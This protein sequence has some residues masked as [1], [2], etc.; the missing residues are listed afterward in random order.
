M[1]DWIG[2]STTVSATLGTRKYKE[3]IDREQHDYYATE[4]K[5][6]SLLLQEETFA[7]RI[8]EP[9]CGEGHISRELIRGGYDVESSDLIDRG[10]GK[11]ADFLQLKQWDGDI[12]TNPPYRY[13]LEFIKHALDI[14]PEGNKVAMFLRILALEGKARGQF[15]VQNPPKAVYVSS[16]RLKCAMNGR[17]DLVTGRAQN[18][19]WFVWEKGYK[20]ETKLSWINY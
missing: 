9:C 5:A 18:Y 4:P 20:G 8:L 11:V 19:A 13:V 15:Y 10:Y 2:N 7:P 17:F 1:K 16:S 3:A 12:I 6:V 14:I